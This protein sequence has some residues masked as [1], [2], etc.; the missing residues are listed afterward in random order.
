[1]TRLAVGKY[2][3]TGELCSHLPQPGDTSLLKSLSSGKIFSS[4]VWSE[5]EETWHYPE[6]DSTYSVAEG[7][8]S[9]CYIQ[10]VTLQ[11]N[12]KLCVSRRVLYTIKKNCEGAL[13]LLH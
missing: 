1:M 12:S 2:S 4:T 6:T 11:G 7:Y 13:L 3:C 5:E 9:W 8:G 10:G